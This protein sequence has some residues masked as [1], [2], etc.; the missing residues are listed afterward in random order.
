[1][2]ELAGDAAGHRL[3]AALFGNSP[4]LTHSALHEPNLL[5]RLVQQGADATF[6]EVLL[7]LNRDLADT[8]GDRASLMR[9]LRIAKRRVAL[10]VAIADIAGWWDLAQVTGALSDFADRALAAAAAHLL[11]AAAARGE[12]AL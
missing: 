4:F 8:T 10:I 7:G 12:I 6:A 11:R 9:I 3:L 2:R 5:R 1:M